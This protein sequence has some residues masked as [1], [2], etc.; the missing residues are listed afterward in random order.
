MSA[1]SEREL[2][3]FLNDAHPSSS[4]YLKTSFQF[5]PMKGLSPKSLFCTV[6]KALQKYYLPLIGSLNSASV[7]I[8][9]NNV[10]V[11]LNS[12]LVS[13]FTVSFQ[14]VTRY[15]F[16]TLSEVVTYKPTAFNQS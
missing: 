1:K 15:T 13:L 6:F 9:L 14:I 3:L 2:C 12:V 8:S 11:S 5:T 16:S 4:V 7:I 10:P